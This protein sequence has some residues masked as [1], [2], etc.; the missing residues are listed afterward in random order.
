MWKGQL[1]LAVEN[2]RE[3]NT[4]EE[5]IANLTDDE[6]CETHWIHARLHEDGTYTVTN[7]RN[8]YSKTYQT[9]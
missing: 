5:R 1:H 4:D 2:D 8:G 3:H 7:S 9:K 6:A